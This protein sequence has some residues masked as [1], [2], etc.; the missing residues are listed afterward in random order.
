VAITDTLEIRCANCDVTSQVNRSAASMTCPDCKGVFTFHECEVCRSIEQTGPD[1]ARGNRWRCRFCFGVNKL[2]RKMPAHTA[3]A[4]HAELDSRGLASRDD[5]RMLGGFTHVG[6]TGFKIAP[7]SV[8]SVTGRVGTVVVRVE[9]GP[10]TGEEAAMRYND[11]TKMEVGG[12]AVTS[13]GGYFG[14]GFGTGALE[15][16]AV[17]SLLNAL[18][19][20]KKV[21]TGL[22][23][24]S[25]NGEVLLHH[26]QYL[27]TLIR[28]KLS[29]MFARH[30][31]AKHQSRL[32]PSMAPQD[33]LS[34]L[35]R[36]VGLRDAGVLSDAEF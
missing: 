14:G 8:C 24:G 1:M 21:N 32:E 7:G 23:I 36:L 29:P 28:N 6:G 4:R 5:V 19:Q 18:T 13:G 34:Q 35:E 11:V 33:P 2:D 26:G 17:A 25:T 10:A 20:K 22:H 9:V 16:I 3:G 30:D 27:P 15:G 12:G 31:A